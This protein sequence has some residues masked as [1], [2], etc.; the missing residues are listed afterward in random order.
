[1]GWYFFVEE[2]FQQFLIL[3]QTVFFKVNFI[4]SS[5]PEK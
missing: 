4:V 5:W 2:T 1:M 3:I